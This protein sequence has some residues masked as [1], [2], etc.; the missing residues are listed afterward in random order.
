MQPMEPHEI[1]LKDDYKFLFIGLD[2]H[3][4]Q[5]QHEISDSSMQIDQNELK[6]TKKILSF[7]SKKFITYHQCFEGQEYF[8][9]FLQKKPRHDFKNSFHLTRRILIDFFNELDGK[10]TTEFTYSY[11]NKS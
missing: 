2:K 3:L 10:N 7:F 8:M 6:Q 11:S 9:L 5:T 4:W 1:A